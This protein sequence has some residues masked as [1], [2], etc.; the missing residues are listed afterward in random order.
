MCATRARFY[1][2]VIAWV[3]PMCVAVVWAEPDIWG[4]V[5]G[6]RRSS[7]WVTPRWDLAQPH[8]RG[9][10]EEASCPRRCD[11]RVKGGVHMLCTQ[12][13]A[14]GLGI[15]LPMRREPQGI[16]NATVAQ[17][18]LTRDPIAPPPTVYC[19]SARC[20]RAESPVAAPLIA[21]TCALQRFRPRDGA[22]RS[23]CRST[24]YR[25]RLCDSFHGPCG[26]WSR[27]HLVL[28]ALVCRHKLPASG[29]SFAS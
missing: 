24:I 27:L 6:N 10:A 12:R 9:H 20:A 28:T 21:L 2:S 29:V 14:G 13:N 23:L 5:L 1:V 8:S 11:V 25:Y 26:F 7:W 22:R 4:E 15:K 3:A 19:F 18:G 16:T 17:D